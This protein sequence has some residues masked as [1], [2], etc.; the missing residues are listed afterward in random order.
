ML[1]F[2]AGCSSDVSS[3]AGAVPTS[4]FASFFG[5]A[6]SLATAKPGFDKRLL[7][8][9][10]ADVLKKFPWS[11]PV[12]PQDITIDIAPASN[13]SNFI[14]PTY[15]ANGGDVREITSLSKQFQGAF[16]EIII[17]HIGNGFPQFLS[18]QQGTGSNCYNQLFQLLR[19]YNS[20]IAPGGTLTYESYRYS[21]TEKNIDV[22]A[23]KVLENLMVSVQ[24]MMNWP[25]Y[26]YLTQ[27]Q[28]NKYLTDFS[29]HVLSNTG[30][31]AITF[32]VKQDLAYSKLNPPQ[33]S[34]YY[35]VEIRARKSAANSSSNPASSIIGQAEGLLGSSD[36]TGVSQGLLSQLPIPPLG[37][38][39]PSSGGG[40]GGAKGG[41]TGGASSGAGG[42]SSLL[43][44]FGK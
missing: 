43:G 20:M 13:P 16:S 28:L 22:G 42:L 2:L 35:Y 26:S 24:K 37:G 32:Q 6:P 21:V 34:P 1:C 29:T 23:L 15:I 33:P 41:N 30:F 17:E 4:G 31:E 12:T 10:G 11:R 44:G 18:C 9:S 3:I 40:A 27:D 14:N 38:G 39:A 36:S 7:V 19:V 25:S 8:G 5:S